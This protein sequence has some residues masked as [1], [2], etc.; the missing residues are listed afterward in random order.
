MKK[1]EKIAHNPYLLFIPFLMAYIFYVLLMPTNGTSSDE[2]RY[3]IY[4]NNLIQGFYSPPGEIWL[5][6][7]PG[8]PII[9]MPFLALNLPFIWITIMNAFFYYF[10]I[11]L[12]YK[13]LK[14]I[15]S[16]RFVLIFSLAW[17]SYLIAYQN[18]PYIHTETFTYFLI[19]LLIYSTIRTFV[20]QKA[21]SLSKY[22]L[23]A[24]FT[25][26]YIVLTKMIFGYVLMFI[27]IG[28][29]LLWILNKNSRNYNKGLMIAI[30]ALFTTLPYLIYTY[31]ITDRIFYWGMGS[32]SLYW[33]TSTN[34]NEYGDWTDPLVVNPRV[35][36]NYNIPGAD[37]VLIANHE[38]DFVEIYKYTG[39]ERDDAFKRLAIRNIKNHPLK[40]LENI[41]YN[42]GR[43]I[44][45]Y[46][47]S[48]AIQK[49]RTLLV[50]PINGIL[51]TLMIY[52]LIITL[53]NWKKLP[54]YLKLLLIIGF[55]YLGASTLVTAFVR[56]F[57]VIVPILLI[58]IAFILQNTL[59]INFKF[60][61]VLTNTHEK[62]NLLEKE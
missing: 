22:T 36:A 21:N 58:W 11:I 51:L 56:M 2:P 6:N 62:E 31:K 59:K 12:L 29:V 61:E 39:I 34:K 1:I 14:E 52:S 5:I 10:S 18:I 42:M 8:Y 24:G 19:T 23:L 26:G 15:V 60:N 50:L 54:Y 28:S 32:D 27:F 20:S 44:F 53:I 57:T 16:F 40:Y 41:V 25:L 4:A 7:G 9:L 43:L 48:E 35:Y 47:F 30:I 45:H 46:P 37:S 38:K 3:L 49:P 55:L 13:A 33:M 17:A